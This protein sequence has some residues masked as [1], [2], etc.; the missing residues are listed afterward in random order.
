MIVSCRHD[1]IVIE[2]ENE[3]VTDPAIIT[4]SD[5]GYMLHGFYLL[6]EGNMGSNKS[7]LDYFDFAS[8]VYTRNI[9]GKANPDVPMELGDVGNDLAIYGS[10]LYAVIN[11]SNKVEVM[12]ANT[13]RRI[14]SIN[15]P[16]C[17]HI[18]FKD[19][20][21]YVTSYAGPVEVRPDYTQRGYVAK[22]DTA[23]LSIVE[24]CIVGYQ[25]DG[26]DILGNRLYAANSG[27]YM[28]PYYDNRLSVISLQ[29]FQQIKEIEIADNLNLVTADNHG[30][31]WITSRGNYYTRQPL[32]TC[33]NVDKS[34]KIFELPI[35]VSSMAILNDTLYAVG[36]EFSYVSMRT[37]YNF[38]AIN[39]L[40]GEK[41]KDSFITPEYVAKF[42]MPYCVAINP[43][44]HDIYVTDAGNYV[45]PGWL[46]CFSSNGEMR[47]RVRT[48]DIPAHITFFAT[49]Y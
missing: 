29:N 4:P 37:E 7:T 49:K 6:N 23:S 42:K 15:I 43:V 17:R 45:T 40:T 48:G 33:Y 11:C 32:L 31:L 41:I 20:Y 22:I 14:N 36:S 46:Y 21:A 27:G 35:A 10:K 34:E 16:N 39:T 44:N 47:W 24:K 18:T 3:N 13:C 5:D 28:E 12:D 38:A 19:G 1:D 2:A 9:Y 30:N 25:P 8:G 26:L